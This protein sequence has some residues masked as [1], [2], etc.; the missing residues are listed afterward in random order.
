MNAIFNQDSRVPSISHLNECKLD[1][2]EAHVEERRVLSEN[3]FEFGQ[4][5]GSCL[6]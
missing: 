4:F 6:L 1:L 5:H 2:I 3:M